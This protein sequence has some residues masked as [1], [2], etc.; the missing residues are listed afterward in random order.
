MIHRLMKEWLAAVLKVVRILDVYT[1][2]RIRCVVLLPI[3]ILMT[4]A[5]LLNGIVI[6][7]LLGIAVREHASIFHGNNA[8]I[9]S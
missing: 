3:L 7:I 2:I 8:S 9:C 5:V 6:G 1:T 4:V